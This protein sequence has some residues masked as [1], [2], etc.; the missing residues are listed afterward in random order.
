MPKDYFN[1]AK[2]VM[3]KGVSTARGK[4]RAGVAAKKAGAR[5]ML[6]G[7]GV[8]SKK[9]GAG[10]MIGAAGVAAA[11]KIKDRVTSRRGN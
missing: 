8:A 11:K 4:V 3:E 6:G 9:A 7:A 10:A 2:N 1:K 5:A